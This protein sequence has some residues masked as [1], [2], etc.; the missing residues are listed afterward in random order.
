MNLES[1]MGRLRNE[2]R[3]KQLADNRQSSTS[4]SLSGSGTIRSVLLLV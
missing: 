1:G 4:G 2:N 3:P